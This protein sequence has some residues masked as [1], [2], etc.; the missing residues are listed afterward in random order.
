MAWHDTAWHDVLCAVRVLYELLVR[1]T[2]GLA[3]DTVIG[4][5]L[6]IDQ[7]ACIVCCV[8]NGN[9]NDNDPTKGIKKFIL[10]YH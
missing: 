10:K 8:S 6:G 9:D 3:L 2:L 7:A 4:P 1:V 5:T